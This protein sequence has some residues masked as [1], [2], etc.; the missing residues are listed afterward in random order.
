MLE[1]FWIP[2]LFYSVCNAFRLARFNVMH[3][4][5]SLETER[6]SYFTGVPA[7]AAA[8]LGGGFLGGMN[9]QQQQPA[10]GGGLFG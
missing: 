5:E 8:G 9:Q 4:G 2:F 1:W 10:G 6:K 3:S 7:P